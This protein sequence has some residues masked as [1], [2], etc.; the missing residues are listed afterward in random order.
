MEHDRCLAYSLANWNIQPLWSTH[1]MHIVARGRRTRLP[2]HVASEVY[3]NS[4]SN[5]VEA[6]RTTG[7]E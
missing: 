4:A 3:T 2:L 1:G 7:F 6:L 5:M